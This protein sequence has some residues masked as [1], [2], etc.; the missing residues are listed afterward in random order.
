[1]NMCD[2]T[3]ILGTREMEQ[4]VTVICFDNRVNTTLKRGGNNCKVETA[5]Y[6]LE[7]TTL[8]SMERKDRAKSSIQYCLGEGANLYHQEDK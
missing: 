6:Y 5:L 3:A 4:Y 1:M 7:K 8:H 2:C